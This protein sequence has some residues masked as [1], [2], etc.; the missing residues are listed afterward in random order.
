MGTLL[1]KNKT[2]WPSDHAMLKVTLY[3]KKK[4]KKKKKKFSRNA[5]EFT[6]A[7]SGSS[8]LTQDER[9]LLLYSPQNYSNFFKIYKNNKLSYLRIK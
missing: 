3:L 2:F 6:P 5:K 4:K 9:Q 8:S 1:K 7:S